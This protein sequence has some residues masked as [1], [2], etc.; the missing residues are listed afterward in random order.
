MILADVLLEGGEEGGEKVAEVAVVDLL[1]VHHG[2]VVVGFGAQ[3]GEVLG[4]KQRRH[5][6]IF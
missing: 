1:V 4:S 2:H 5:N 6:T 3:H